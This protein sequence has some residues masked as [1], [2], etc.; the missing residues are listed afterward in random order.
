MCHSNKLYFR[1]ELLSIKTM[2]P[3]KNKNI[4]IHLVKLSKTQRMV[5][6]KSSFFFFPSLFSLCYRLQWQLLWRQ[7]PVPTGVKLQW[8]QPFSGA[9]NPPRQE[10]QEERPT[11]SE[12]M[13][14]PQQL[15]GT[16]RA[17][18]QRRQQHHPQGICRYDRHEL[19]LFVNSSSTALMS[20]TGRRGASLLPAV[21][22]SRICITW[23]HCGAKE[24]P[25]LVGI[26]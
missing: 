26:V 15:Q 17:L 10:V 6:G 25:L 5:N 21:I 8:D 3:C 19:R 24:A 13:L 23:C 9:G 7:L 20:A 18:L 16:L 12:P 4:H 22:D 14:C 11:S 2:F 1:L